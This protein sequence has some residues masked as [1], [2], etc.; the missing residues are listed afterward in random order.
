MTARDALP[1]TVTIDTDQLQADVSRQWDADIIPQL[2][3][4]VKIPAKSPGFDRDWAKNGYLDAAI[5]LAR[6]W[7]AAQDVVGITLVVVRVSG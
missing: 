4:Y 3:E 5:E 2:I 1:S 7:V 6:A